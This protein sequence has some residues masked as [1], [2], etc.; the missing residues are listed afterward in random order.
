VVPRVRA[1][2]NGWELGGMLTYDYLRSIEGKDRFPERVTNDFSLTDQRLRAQAWLAYTLPHSRFQ[3]ALN[4]EYRYRQGEMLEVSDAT[5]E[6]RYMG[7]VGLL[8]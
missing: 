7:S 6:Y 5:T 3:L 8:F 1:A 4:V 2:Y